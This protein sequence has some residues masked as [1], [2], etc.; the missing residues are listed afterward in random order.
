MTL[1]TAQELADHVGERIMGFG[2]RDPIALMEEGVHFMRVVNQMRGVPDV[3]PDD[4]YEWRSVSE[5]LGR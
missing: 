5:L 1:M 2:Y 3:E 4:V